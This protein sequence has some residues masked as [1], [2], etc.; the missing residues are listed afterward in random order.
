MTNPMFARK[1]THRDVNMFPVFRV[2]VINAL[3]QRCFCLPS[4]CSTFPST[5][6]RIFVIRQ[7]KL[8]SSDLITKTLCFIKIKV[9][10]AMENYPEIRCG[11]TDPFMGPLNGSHVFAWR[12]MKTTNLV[13]SIES[14]SP[15]HSFTLYHQIHANIRSLPSDELMANYQLSP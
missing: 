1:K 2:N 10:R 14:L 3:I 12:K 6:E 9:F 8:F 15:R 11:S 5:N 7:P 4:D 13:D